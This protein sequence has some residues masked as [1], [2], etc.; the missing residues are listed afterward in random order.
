MG[1]VLEQQEGINQ[2]LP[3]FERCIQLD[4]NH[5]QGL[6]NVGRYYYNEATLVA[7]RYPR[8]SGRALSR[9]AEPLY[10]EA[11]P[12]LEKSYQIDPTNE[13]VRN[14]LRNIYYHLGDAAK[15]QALEQ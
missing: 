5:P 12:Y 4:P 11:L 14:A 2:A 6:F 13:D 7:E 8:L 1:L 9:K 15:L 3:H 10:K